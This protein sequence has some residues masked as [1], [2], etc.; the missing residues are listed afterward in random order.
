M[1]GRESHFAKSV[2]RDFYTKAE[3]IGLAYFIVEIAIRGF[4]Y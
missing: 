4:Q 2:G 3:A 1:D